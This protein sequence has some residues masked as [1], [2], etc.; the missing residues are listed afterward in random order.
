M[1]KGYFMTLPKG[2]NE[3]VYHAYL[4]VIKRGSGATRT[5]PRDSKA[6]YLVVRPSDPDTV[7]WGSEETALRR[8]KEDPN[9]VELHPYLE[10]V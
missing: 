7:M 10:N 8:L 3:E 2:H 1:S 9:M 6:I 5:F 4:E